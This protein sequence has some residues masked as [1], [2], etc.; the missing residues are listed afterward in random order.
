MT[1]VTS[2]L[3]LILVLL[4][5]ALLVAGC[6][7]SPKD[8]AETLDAKDLYE[9]ANRSVTAGQYDSAVTYYKR[10]QAR[11]PFGPYAS[12]GL[13]ELAYAHWKN[14]QPEEAIAVAD[15]FIREHPTHPHVDYAYY[16][17]GLINFRRQLSITERLFPYERTTRDQTHAQQAFQAFQEL[18]DKYPASRYAAD[19]RQRM[20]HLRNNI[21]Q[22][23]LNIAEYYLSRNAFVAA[24]N[25]AKKIVES[26]DE[27]P[28]A[29]GA[30]VVMAKGYEALNMPELAGDARR[31]LELNYPEH[32]YLTGEGEK[33]GFFSR[34]WPFS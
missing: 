22:H 29:P 3:R 7:T 33:K 31:V 15:R 9:A 4:A 16:L 28:A 8:R 13:I 18:L 34:L 19:A 12:Q 27:T 25:R 5:A 21:A 14:Y 1:I 2:P 11:F 17:K 6:G 32:P 24:V 26:Y 23:E 30:L 10:L 20:V